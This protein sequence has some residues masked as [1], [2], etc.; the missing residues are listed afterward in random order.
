MSVQDMLK[1]M[2]SRVFNSSYDS[3][4]RNAYDLWAETDFKEE[5]SDYAKGVQALDSV[6]TE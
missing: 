5:E 2:S 3:Y 4:M 1:E 6:L